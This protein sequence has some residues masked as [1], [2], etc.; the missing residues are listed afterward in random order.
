M[1][2]GLLSLMAGQIQQ[3]SQRLCCD[4]SALLFCLS[5]N[6]LHWNSKSH[7]GRPSRA[8]IKTKPHSRA[9]CWHAVRRHLWIKFSHTSTLHATASQLY[10][11]IVIE[12]HYVILTWCCPSQWCERASPVPLHS[13]CR[14]RRRPGTLPETA[15]HHLQ[16]RHKY[17][18]SSI[19]T[20]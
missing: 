2:P 16:E 7:R 1:I 17:I 3:G 15:C 8:A 11:V 12:Y 9:H 13:G 10:G 19:P 14:Q 18:W 4:H 20:I 5:S 6:F